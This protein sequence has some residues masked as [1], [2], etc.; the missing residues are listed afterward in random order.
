MSRTEFKK[1]AAVHG[2]DVAKFLAQELGVN[3][4]VVE[5]WSMT[6]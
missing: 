5:L 2:V 4:A 6:K 1:V 3:T